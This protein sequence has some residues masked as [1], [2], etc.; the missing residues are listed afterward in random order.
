MINKF[1]N[2]TLQEAAETAVVEGRL[3][4]DES[5]SAGEVEACNEDGGEQYKECEEQERTLSAAPLY[6]SEGMSMNAMMDDMVVSSFSSFASSAAP[7][8]EVQLQRSISP[9]AA[10]SGRKRD[11]EQKPPAKLAPPAKTASKPT[12]T[13]TTTTTSSASPKEKQGEDDRTKKE[14][15]KQEDK[16]NEPTEAAAIESESAK[17][18]TAI[19]KGAI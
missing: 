6:A 2:A 17:D 3:D 18:L 15:P 5:E 11:E 19:P 8:Q 14:E 13:T 12:T 4:Y 16:K 10:S 1:K 9:R 7:V